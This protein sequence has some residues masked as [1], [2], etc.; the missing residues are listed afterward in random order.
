ML[1]L[2]FSPHMGHF[3][4]WFRRLGAPIVALIYFLSLLVL[5]PDDHYP[6]APPS[7]ISWSDWKQLTAALSFSLLLAYG[8]FEFGNWQHRW[9]DRHATWS[10]LRQPAR[11]VLTQVGT[12]V[13]M[14]EVFTLVFVQLYLGLIGEPGPVTLPDLLPILL[15]SLYTA[16]LLSGVYIGASFFSNWQAEAQA[17]EEA[18]ADAAQA[19]LHVLQQQLDPHF[20]FNTLSTLTAVIEADQGRA[21]TFVQ[22]LATVYR[23]VL[24]HRHTARVP[25]RAELQLVKAYLYLLQTRYP[26]GLEVEIMVDPAHC[27]RLVLPMVV[28]LLVENAVKHNR[29][30]PDAPLHIRIQTTDEWLVVENNRQPLTR[31]PASTGVG[32]RNVTR[33][34]EAAEAG[35]AVRVEQTAEWFRVS[36]PLLGEPAAESSADLAHLTDPLRGGSSLKEKEA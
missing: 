23:Y 20:L 2:P 19:R 16:L 15:S 32:L 14:T 13:L 10:W 5:Y 17:R 21:V 36:L 18:M 30:E 31:P 33:R 7:E 29:I 11:R 35:A 4:R 8:V 6:G 3:L 1:V 34:Y 22:R 27:A 12:L 9:M 25:L 26:L 28:Q 24:Q